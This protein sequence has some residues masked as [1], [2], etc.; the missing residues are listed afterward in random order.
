VQAAVAAT[1][2]VLLHACPR[3]TKENKNIKLNVQIYQNG[4]ALREANQSI[5]H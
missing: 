2:Q 5:L 3:P 1:R 4:E